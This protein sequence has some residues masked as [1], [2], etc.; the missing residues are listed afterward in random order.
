MELKMDQDD[1]DG[2]EMMMLDSSD[3]H[4]TI[5]SHAGTDEG[6]VGTLVQSLAAI[7][8][9]KKQNKRNQSS[10][11]CERAEKS[12][13]LEDLQ[14]HSHKSVEEAAKSPDGKPLEL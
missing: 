8:T 13:H 1:D 7:S 9:V 5:E 2:I 6:D 10:T 12:V 3:Q 14:Q 4:P 11:I